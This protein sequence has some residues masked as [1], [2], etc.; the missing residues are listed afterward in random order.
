[1]NNNIHYYNYQY[2]IHHNKS[3]LSHHHINYYTNNNNLLN[4]SI[5]FMFLLIFMHPIHNTFLGGMM[6]LFIYI[7]SLAS[8][9]MF[10]LPTKT[11]LIFTTLI[12][13]LMMML[14]NYNNHLLSNLLKNES[15]MNNFINL[16]MES[17]N[18]NQLYNYPNFSLTIT[19]IIY[20]LITLIIIVKITSFQEGPLRHSN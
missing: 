11:M 8:N 16:S 17:N 12:P 15:F 7:T 9:E 19:T 1:M 14:I 3:S 10:Q 20:L 6:V 18:L 4:H 2:N 13:M 5:N